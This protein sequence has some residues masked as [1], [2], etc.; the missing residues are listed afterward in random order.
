MEGTIYVRLDYKSDTVW[1][2]TFHIFHIFSDFMDMCIFV[3]VHKWGLP[4][5]VTIYVRS[6]ML[7]QH[8]LSSPTVRT[9]IC[10]NRVSLAENA[11]ASA[12]GFSIFQ[13]RVTAKSG[14]RPPPSLAR[15]Q[16][17]KMI[18]LVRSNE[19]SFLGGVGRCVFWGWA[20]SSFGRGE[21]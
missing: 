16:K 18:K 4:A 13:T 6:P 11:A 8:L 9:D 12:T 5:N 21:G 17:P 20:A 19:C 10:V 3:K 2:R 7:L 1:A 15:P 14:L